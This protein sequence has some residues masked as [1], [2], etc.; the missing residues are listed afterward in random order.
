MLSPDN[1][2]GHILIPRFGYRLQPKLS[3]ST[4]LE[5]ALVCG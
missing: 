2:Y 5:T 3:D 1:I 4:Q